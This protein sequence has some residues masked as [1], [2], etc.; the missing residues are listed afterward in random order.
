MGIS[1]IDE[2]SITGA[3]NY[4]NSPYDHGM[5]H[6]SINHQFYQKQDNLRSLNYLGAQFHAATATHSPP[7]SDLNPISLPHL[8][9]S[10]PPR[11]VRIF[12]STI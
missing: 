6:P 5:N 12:S 4:S 8:G 10:M 7:L 3:V 11:P 9:S 2:N 1:S